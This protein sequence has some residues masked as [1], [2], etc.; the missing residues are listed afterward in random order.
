LPLHLRLL[1]PNQRQRALRMIF[2]TSPSH[3]L[4]LG[5]LH[6]QSL[7]L[8]SLLR[9]YLPPTSIQHSIFRPQ[10]LLLNPLPRKRWRYSQLLRS[11]PRRSLIW[12]LGVPAMLGL[13]QSLPLPVQ[14][15]HPNLL[16]QQKHLP[17]LC[18]MTSPPGAAHQRLPTLNPLPSATVSTA[19]RNLLRRLLR[20]R[21]LEVGV[22]LRRRLPLQASQ[23][24]RLASLQVAGSEEVMI[25]SQMS[26]NERLRFRPT[27]RRHG[28]GPR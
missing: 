6:L 13:H 20:T 9:P 10:H 18:Q 21:T 8:R 16:H 7:H 4:Q 12:T 23:R 19:P 2:S 25:C 11:L 3:L 15:L 27:E 1:H 17:F 14:H 24:L 28:C 5:H 22:A 26:G